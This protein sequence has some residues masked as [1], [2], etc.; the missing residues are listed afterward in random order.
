MGQVVELPSRRKAAPNALNGKVR[1]PTRRPNQSTRKRE[2]LTADEVERL[3]DATGAGTRYG[4]RDRALLLL[5][6][7]H[8][9]RVS[10]AITLRWDQVDL[11]AG[12]LAVVRLKNGVPSTHPLRGP[13]LRAL[14]QLR[15]DWPDSPYLFVSERGGPMTA[16]NV[17]K[18]VTRAGIQ[19]KI[20]YPV[21]P[22]MLRHAC[23][24]KLANEGHD[25][26]S[27]QHYL[28]H[29]NIAHTVRYT[30]MASDRFKS[31]WRD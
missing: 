20:E 25:T 13:E 23:G 8:G 17:R 30:D 14:R 2:Y 19:A 7:R 6:Y 31:F 11:K 22:H 18:L 24:Y 10:E 27:L 1:P 29:K 21:H 28:G 16:S 12:H 4:P 3:M 5:M 15:R 26:R 9:L